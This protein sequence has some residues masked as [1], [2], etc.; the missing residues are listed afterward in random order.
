MC[1]ILLEIKDIF[2]YMVNTEK[3]IEK[4]VLVSVKESMPKLTSIGYTLT[5]GIGIVKPV[6]DNK[7]NSQLPIL[8][9]Y[10]YSL[11]RRMAYT[12]L[13]PKRRRNN[14]RQQDSHERYAR[15]YSFGGICQV[16]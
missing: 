10:H 12:F 11:N 15:S 4:V 5:K 13:D 1:V 6:N 16:K 7:Y 14:Y 2:I 8:L 3:I 9:S